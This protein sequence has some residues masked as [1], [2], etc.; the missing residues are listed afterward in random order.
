MSAAGNK[1]QGVWMVLAIAA[2]T[3]AHSTQA[4]VPPEQ[5]EAYVLVIKAEQAEKDGDVKT[6]Q[7][8]YTS[9]L[10]TYRQVGRENPKWRPDLVQYRIAHCLNQIERLGREL[11]KVAAPEELPAD[12]TEK[13]ELDTIAA[14]RV[15]M[16]A[17]SEALEI[18]INELETARTNDQEK[19]RSLEK[20]VEAAREASVDQD[21]L[22][23]IRETNKVLVKEKQQLEKTIREIKAAAENLETAYGQDIKQKK[24]SLD[25]VEQVL[26]SVRAEKEQLELQITELKGRIIPEKQLLAAQAE[27]KNVTA[28]NEA[29]KQAVSGQEATIKQLQEKLT[30]AEQRG[31]DMH[32][33]FEADR[34]K[35]NREVAALKETVDLN[36]A[37]VQKTRELRSTIKSLEKQIIPEK[38]RL[39]EKTERDNLAEENKSLR[40]SMNELNDQVKY[41]REQLADVEKELAGANS[42]H[43]VEKAALE[44]E[45]A[46]LNGTVE[47]NRVELKAVKEMRAS[48]SSLEKE[49]AALAGQVQELQGEL[50]GGRVRL[51][52]ENKRLQSQNSVLVEEVQ[53]F[54]ERMEKTERR[55]RDYERKNAGIP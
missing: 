1:W 6:A 44:K 54:R 8:L 29:L 41:I 48:V 39:A 24:E 46:A 18:R 43:V 12:K 20:A 49:K 28:E 7:E 17:K 34:E 51:E 38:Q 40:N 42:S 19:I 14:E 27:Q 47:N 23:K 31:V 32:T 11:E 33:T 50:E 55:L 4:Q 45:L 3:G 15:E 36:L 16:M 5:V 37:D 25:R 52:N 30:L 10:K 22:K 13:A 21:G 35:L 2:L 26:A 53:E 9:A